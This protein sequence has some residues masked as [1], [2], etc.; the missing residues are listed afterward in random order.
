MVLRKKSKTANEEKTKKEGIE[1]ETKV[2]KKIELMSSTDPEM[3]PLSNDL[4]SE[5]DLFES[6][7]KESIETEQ[8]TFIEPEKVTSVVSEI[9]ETS[10]LERV[11]TAQSE[12]FLPIEPEIVE[13]AEPKRA[14]IAESEKKKPKN[15]ESRKAKAKTSRKA[16][17]K[18]S[19]KDGN[20]EPEKQKVKEPEIEEVKETEKVKKTSPEE[21]T[22]IKPVKTESKEELVDITNITNS[23]TDNKIQAS[24]LAIYNE[25]AELKAN[26]EKAKKVIRILKKKLDLAE[27]KEEQWRICANSLGD[28]FAEKSHMPLEDVLRRFEAPLDEVEV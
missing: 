14:E 27:E 2:E 9:V 15:N 23:I 26:L 24:V 16:K 13:L 3:K 11:G 6:E 20:K 22:V 8:V 4:Q 5:I 10:E 25:N 18:K 28:I 21:K 7:I 1:Q 17:A 19:K 12:T